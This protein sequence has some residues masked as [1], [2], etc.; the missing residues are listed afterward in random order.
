MWVRLVA[1]IPSH[2]VVSAHPSLTQDTGY[3]GSSPR[4]TVSEAG[5]PAR[6]HR[7]L[8]LSRGGGHSLR[9][10]CF[11]S[12]FGEISDP[13]YHPEG[14]YEFKIDLNGDAIED[15][16]YRITSMTGTLP[17]VNAS[18]CVVS[19]GLTRTDPHASGTVLLRVTHRRNRHRSK[20][21]ARGRMRTS[22]T[23]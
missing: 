18:S 12:I 14:M 2:R 20:R 17:P 16:T 9:N 1:A 21:S 15:V 19:Q 22:I 10:Q 6:Y 23:R 13:G 7:P 3:Y 8:S 11:H 5:H 4:F